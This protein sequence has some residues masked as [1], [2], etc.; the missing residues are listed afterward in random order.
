MFPESEEWAME[1][2]S[3]WATILTEMR[4]NVQNRATSLL[5]NAPVPSH[6]LKQS[7]PKVYI[8]A[9]AH[10]AIPQVSFN[11]MSGRPSVNAKQL[12]ARITTPG[13]QSLDANC[14]IC[15]T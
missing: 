2:P 7:G 15:P 9:A 12:Y 10:V 11:S 1:D 8:S 3:S 6:N 4:S 13:D 5:A 14:I